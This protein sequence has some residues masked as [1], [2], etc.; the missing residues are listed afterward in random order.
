MKGCQ[1]MGGTAVKEC[2][3]MGG[4]AVS[5]DGR[6]FCGGQ[7]ING[8]GYTVSPLH[9]FTLSREGYGRDGMSGSGVYGRIV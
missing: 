3:E 4:T 8:R 2:H 9:L 1:E 6:A 7:R 5:F